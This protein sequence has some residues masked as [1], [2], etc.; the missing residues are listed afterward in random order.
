MIWPPLKARTSKFIIDH[1]RHFVAINYG[2]KKQN[3]WVTLMS[4]IDSE[5]VIEVSWSKLLDHSY[6]EC[7]WEEDN[8][9]DLSKLVAK[10][11]EIKISNLSH[12]SEDSGLTIPITKNVIRPWID[13][14]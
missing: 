9:S 11:S 10:K 5:L 7:G 2:G 1:Q 8:N 12:P 3:R 6:W 14:T 13:N 4:V